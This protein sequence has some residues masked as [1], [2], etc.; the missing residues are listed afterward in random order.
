MSSQR[1]NEHVI[2]AET[3]ADS[4][5]APKWYLVR[6]KTNEERIAHHHL[7]GLAAEV[8][9]PLLRVRVRRWGRMV[10]SVGPLFP[11]Y[12]FALFD[13]DRQCARVSFT[14]GVREIVRFGL[15]PAEVARWIVDEIKDRCAAGPIE[16]APPRYSPGE[17]V[18]V[19]DGPLR[20]FEGVFQHHL[21]GAERVAI[22]LSAMGAVRAVMPAR[23]IA[24]IT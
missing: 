10:D 5:G 1:M 2:E 17:P 3:E 16:L 15:C 20:G 12:L 19:V 24:P 11:S 22:L 14:R 13:Y 4:E 18:R 9:L 8:L 23:M 7:S 21:S 6:T